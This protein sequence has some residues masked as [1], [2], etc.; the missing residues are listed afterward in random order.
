MNRLMKIIR[1]IPISWLVIE[2]FMKYIKRVTN[3]QPFGYFIK[4]ISFMNLEY[5]LT[6]VIDIGRD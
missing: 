1:G 6:C 3:H 4:I 2:P 5:K